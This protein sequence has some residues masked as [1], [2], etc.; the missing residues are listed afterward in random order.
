MTAATKAE[1][2]GA[3]V[4]TTQALDELTPATAAIGAWTVRVHQDGKVVP[5]SYQWGGK[6]REG[7]KVEVTLIGQGGES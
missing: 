6:S 1:G 3:V 2:N 4:D 7:K 5:Y